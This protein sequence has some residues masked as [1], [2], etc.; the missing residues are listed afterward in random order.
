M[1]KDEALKLAL[2]ALEAVGAEFVCRATHHHKK[3]QHG[4]LDDC[5][6]QARHEK[7]ITA[8]KQALAAPVQPV[9]PSLW[10]QYHAAQPAPVEPDW[11]AEYLK[12]VES[13]CITLDELREARA[14]LDATNRQVEILSDALAKSRREVA[15]IK[16]AFAAQQEHEPENEPYVSLASV[17]EPVAWVDLLKQAEEV[18]RSKSLWK[19]YIDG[20]PL[21][22]DIAVWM[23]SFAQ[24]HATPPAQ[25][26]WVG[27]TD[28]DVREILLATNANT[29][30]R[31]IE[32]KLKEKNT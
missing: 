6:N 10:E 32:A 9:K 14:E 5:P 25:R 19:K 13:G 20:T 8:I 26:P 24:E 30:A 17:Q 16:Q 18:V 31:A 27:L 4:G 22:N 1:D 29:Y 23:A 15:A 28:E 12:S 3:D 7:A 21:A 2:E 11:K